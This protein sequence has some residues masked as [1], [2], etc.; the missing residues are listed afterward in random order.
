MVMYLIVKNGAPEKYS[1]KQL[2]RDN[3]NTSF[4]KVPS[5]A[6]LADWDVYPYT[7]QDKPKYDPITQGC[8]EGVFVQIEGRWVLP[9]KITQLSPEEIERNLIQ[10]HLRIERDRLRSYQVVSDPLFFKWQAGESTEE[11][12][13]AA[14]ALVKELYPDAD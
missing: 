2:R 4:P 14:R 10:K 13:L 9:W 7:V 8:V 3:P 1:I 5:D 6:L 12:W 11:E